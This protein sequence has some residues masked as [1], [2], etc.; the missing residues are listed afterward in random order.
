MLVISD[1]GSF[2]L[3]C[4]VSMVWIIGILLSIHLST[5]SKL[6]W[7]FFLLFSFFSE[8]AVNICETCSLGNVQLPINL[9]SGETCYIINIHGILLRLLLSPYLRAFSF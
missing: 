7:I 2:L 8:W 5:N 9:Q 4:I 6:V 3:F 1:F